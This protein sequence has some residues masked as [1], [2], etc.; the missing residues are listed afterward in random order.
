MPYYRS[1]ALKISQG[2]QKVFICYFKIFLLIIMIFQSSAQKSTKEKIK[3]KKE[4]TF[5]LGTLE[6]SETN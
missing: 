4:N 3:P 5:A 6:I 2:F 1:N